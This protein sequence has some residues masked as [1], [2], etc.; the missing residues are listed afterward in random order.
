[1]KFISRVISDDNQKNLVVA[2]AHKIY[3]IMAMLM[4][5]FAL[6]DKIKRCYNRD[7]QQ[8][9][10]NLLLSNRKVWIVG[11]SGEKKALQFIW[12]NCSKWFTNDFLLSWRFEFL[13]FESLWLM[14][15]QLYCFPHTDTK[16]IHRRNSHGQHG[17]DVRMANYDMHMNKYRT[18]R[19]QKERFIEDT[20]RYWKVML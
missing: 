4:W 14:S 17:S 1:M 15:I 10:K 12:A 8:N 9:K 19:W 18:D 3:N 13:Y 11:I 5:H 7:S 20:N 16:S 6:Y 2:V